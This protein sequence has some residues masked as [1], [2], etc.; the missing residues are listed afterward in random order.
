MTKLYPGVAQF[1]SALALGARG[2][3]FE[4]S[5]P[6]FLN[7]NKKSLE[8]AGFPSGFKA[9]CGYNIFEHMQ[10]RNRCVQLN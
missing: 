8:S 9:F 10:N 7:P 6:D 1:G 5:H 2:R 3:W 4:S